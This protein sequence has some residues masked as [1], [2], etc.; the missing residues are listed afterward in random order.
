MYNK[1]FT[2]ILILSLIIQSIGIISPSIFP[3]A[4]YILP[5]PCDDE[6]NAFYTDDD[7]SNRK[8]IDIFW[9]E[10]NINL[11]NDNEKKILDDIQNKMIT[12][13]RL[14]KEDIAQMSELKDII[15]KNKLAEYEYYDFKE[16]INK[17]TNREKLTTEEVV[18]LKSYF[19]SIQ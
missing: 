3:Y 4:S 19:N 5:C 8:Y 10:N 13:N 2:F 14:D 17:K 15:F 11:L 18:R 12:N 6:F 16:I 1:K 7:S 9:T